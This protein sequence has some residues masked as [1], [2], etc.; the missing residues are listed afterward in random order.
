MS[1]GEHYFSASPDSASTPRTLVVTLAGQRLRVTTDGGVFS[2]QRLDT[3]TRVLLDHVPTPPAG[4]ELLDLGTGWGPVAL[5]LALLAP[6]AR[7]WAVDVNE[8]A[9]KLAHDNASS[10]GLDN[11]MTALPDDV[12]EDVRFETIWSNPP[13]RIGKAALHEL[14]LRWLPRLR[15]N[16]DAYLVVQRNLG[17]DSLHRWLQEQL[18]GAYETTRETSAKG[19]RVLRVHRSG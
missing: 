11:V 8:R 16:G 14:L 13:I 4:G 15:P 2:P 1:T 19:F 10:H 12:P 17:S 7:V 18:G 5:S 3:G 6:D 9:L